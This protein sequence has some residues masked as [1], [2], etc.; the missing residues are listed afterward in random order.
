MSIFFGS[1]VSRV[2]RFLKQAAFNASSISNAFF[3]AAS[4]FQGGLIGLAIVSWYSLFVFV[5]PG[6]DENV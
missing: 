4:L 6:A 1:Y 5:S 2:I 3:R